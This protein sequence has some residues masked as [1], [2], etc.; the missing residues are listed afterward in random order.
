M[1]YAVH[2]TRKAISW[3]NKEDAAG[4]SLAEWQDYI[5]TDPE[6]RSVNL[7]VAL[8]DGPGAA[9]RPAAAGQCVWLP[10]SK[11]GRTGSYASF[12]H[13]GDRV[14][15]QNPDEEILGKMQAIAHALHARVQGDDDE[16]F[17]EPAQTYG[18]PSPGSAA[19]AGAGADFR[20]FQT[21]ASAGA[22][23]PLLDALGQR[24]IV[25]HTT[26]DTGQVAFDPSFAN[27]QLRGYPN[28]QLYQV[29]RAQAKWSMAR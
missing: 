12:L 6:M 8:E 24:G 28:R 2:I 13:E 15:V 9:G 18:P 26:F 17:D 11:T 22:A 16:Y 3:A 5:A 29:I 14:T 23:Q 7:V 25:Y 10:Y 27:N 4:I 1:G 21:F 19:G 20:D